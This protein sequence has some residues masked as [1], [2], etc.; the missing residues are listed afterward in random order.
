MSK[1]SQ[2]TTSNKGSPTATRKPCLVLRE[3][4]Q[5]VRKSLHNVWDL[6]SIRC[7]QMKEKKSQ[8]Q[9]GNWCSP[10]Q[11]QKSDILKRVDK[12]I[13]LKTSRKLGPENQ[14]RTETDERKYSDSK[15][16]RTLAALSPE[17]INLE[18]T[19]HHYMSKMF[20]CLQRNWE[21]LQPTQ[22]SQWT[23]TRQMYRFVVFL[24]LRR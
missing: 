4:E 16:S 14:N 11:I 10:S 6:G 5:G 1:R 17:L 19:N 23:H 7:M 15:S 8:Q 9:P 2:K 20:Q 3:R 21:C 24:R 12:R 18:Y 22:H 13:S